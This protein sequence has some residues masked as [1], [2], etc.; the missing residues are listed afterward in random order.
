MPTPVDWRRWD[1]IQ[2]H[3][4]AALRD[5]YVPLNEIGG[6]GSAVQRAKKTLPADGYRVSDSSMA[7]WLWTQSKRAAAGRDHRLPDWSLYKR[8]KIVPLGRAGAVRS[9]LLTSAQNDADIHHPFWRNLQAYASH[10]EAEIMVGQFTYQ[11]RYVEDRARSDDSRLHRKREP[12]WHPSLEP[13]LVQETREIGPIVF[14]G[15]V[16]TLPTN[17]APIAGF[18][19]YGRGRTCVFPHAKQQLT[20]IATMPGHPV[21]LAMTTGCVTLED[22]TDTRAGQ[23]A[24][25]HHTYGAILVETD[26]GGTAHIRRISATRDGAFQDLDC[27][28]RSGRVSTGHRVE[29][30]VYGDIQSPFLDPDVARATWGFDVETWKRDGDGLVDALKPAYAFFHDLVDFKSISHHER[31]KLGERFR[32]FV[33]GQHLVERD[34]RLAARFLRGACRDFCRGVVVGSNH[35]RWFD[36]WLDDPSNLRDQ[37]NALAFHRFNLA[38]YEAIAAGDDAFDAFWHALRIVDDDPLEGVEFAPHGRSFVICPNDGGVECGNH[39]DLGSNGSRGTVRGL[40]K[41]STRIVTGDGHSPGTFDGH[42]RAGTSSLLDLRYNKGPSSWCHAHVLVYPTGK[43][44][45]L[46]ITNGKWRA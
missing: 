20:A 43:R 30:V 38:R 46:F 7:K 39:G 41:V 11:V 26:S 4:E 37:Y 42:D 44:T 10:L 5:G 22:Y 16:N 27:V 25:F 17:G 21:P 1:T 12:K 8:P 15:E 9:V 23:K 33:N 34:L 40:A 45:H 14:A 2:R 3:I 32:T 36:R 35:D 29:A 19:T 6:K 18:E 13:F 28:V 31:N 24:A